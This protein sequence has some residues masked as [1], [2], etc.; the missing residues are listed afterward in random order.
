MSDTDRSARDSDVG[1][2]GD[3]PSVSPSDRERVMGRF[4]GKLDAMLANA[5]PPPEREEPRGATPSSTAHADTLRSPAAELP[6][7]HREEIA[8]RVPHG[9]V[10]PAA[11]LPKV[12]SAPSSLKSTEPARELS[13]EA[14][15]R[16]GALPFRPVPPGQ[17]PAGRGAAKTLQ[18]PVAGLEPG[19]TAP[20]GDEGIAKALA[21]LPF[22][23]SAGGER[24]VSFPRLTLEQ[25]VSLREDLVARP[26]RAS[27]TQRHYGVPSEAAQRALDDHWRAKLAESAELR[28]QHDAAVATYRRW[29][30]G[31]SR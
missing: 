2:E 19:K 23:V 11:A 14:W 13:A 22:A 7:A 16:R 6:G 17:P 1:S 27:E 29:L 18:T 25:Y 12:V 15:A 30:A 5:A 3:V 8:A 20:L 31:T 24:V 9:E 21:I 4:F 10:A 26:D 28:A